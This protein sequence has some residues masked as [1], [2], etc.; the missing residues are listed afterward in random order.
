MDAVPTAENAVL[1]TNWECVLG[2]LDNGF[3]KWT[4]SD[5]AVMFEVQ[6]GSPQID[7]SPL[8]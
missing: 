1:S 7:M 5:N 3:C 6:V 2:C 4:N 8:Y